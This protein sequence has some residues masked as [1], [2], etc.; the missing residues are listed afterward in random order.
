[1]SHDHFRS[2]PAAA[3]D[4]LHGAVT[5]L[6]MNIS[7]T[8]VHAHLTPTGEG[9]WN[10]TWTNAGHPPPLLARPGHP[11]RQL[12]EHDL[13]LYPGLPARR[14]QH[15]VRLDPGST[16]LLY[17]DG[18]IEEPG[19]PVDQRIQQLSRLLA[20]NSTTSVEGL[21]EQI[22]DQIAG[23]AHDDD[24]ALLIVRIDTS[25]MVRTEPS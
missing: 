23:P 22:A 9:A 14:T 12:Q 20:E 1:A 6:G 13:L 11:I 16:L 4:A 8:L 15:R 17:T 24:I 21:L 25:G 5:D 2:G 3:V 7:G 18:L 19:T 10:F